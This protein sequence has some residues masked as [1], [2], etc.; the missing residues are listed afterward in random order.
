M[1]AFTALF[2]ALVGTA[3]WNI[4]LLYTAFVDWRVVQHRGINGALQTLAFARMRHKCVRMLIHGLL[5][6]VL[7]PRVVQ[8]T[9]HEPLT[10]AVLFVVLVIALLFD[11]AADA[12]D[13][14]LLRWFL[15]GKVVVKDV[16]AA[17][18]KGRV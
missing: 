14:R 2:V 12:Y 4:Y 18:Q 7:F 10:L 3:V 1:I 9:A 5:I 16:E 13:I 11:V 8:R 6:A 17:K 15:E